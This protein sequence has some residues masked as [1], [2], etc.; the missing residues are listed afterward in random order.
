MLTYRLRETGGWFAA[1]LSH[2]KLIGAELSD[3]R[4]FVA[5]GS[6]NLRSCSSY[7]QFTITHDR[8]LFDFY[9]RALEE[10]RAVEIAKTEPRR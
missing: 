10:I 7:E 3:G 1:A 9:A 8:A 5:E 4:Y 2:M 6:A